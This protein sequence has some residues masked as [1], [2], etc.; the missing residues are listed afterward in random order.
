MRIK[1]FVGIGILLLITLLA[2]SCDKGRLVDAYVT[3]PDNGWNKD[4]LAFFVVDVPSIEQPMN[5]YLNVRNTPQYTSSNLWLFVDVVSPSGK[6]ERD[7]VECILSDLHGKWIGK[8]WGSIYHVKRPYKMGIRFA[9]HG[10]YEF[11]LSHGMRSNDLKG[12]R[13]IGLRVEKAQ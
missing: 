2:A 9:E 13:D 11:K 1:S 8:G 4:S 6:Y 5:I 12:I 7:T 10:K 3:V